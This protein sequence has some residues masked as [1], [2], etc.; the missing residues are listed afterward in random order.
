VR[1]QVVVPAIRGRDVAGAQWSGIRDRVDA[2]QPLDF[3][4]GPL[5]VHPSQYGPERWEG[6]L[7]GVCRKMLAGG[8][9][10]NCPTQAKERLEWAACPSWFRSR[11]LSCRIRLLVRR[12]CR[13]N[14]SYRTLSHFS[15]RTREMGH[16][17]C[18]KVIT[19]G[20]ST[21]LGMT[22][23]WWVLTL[24]AEIL[25][26]ESHAGACDSAASG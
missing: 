26:W 6:Q 11:R 4:N 5:G 8:L 7:A 12:R 15:H 16:P 9:G 17:V 1:E 13:G 20:P 19:Q 22:G 2:L 3:G 14:R 18:P 25:R 10:G 21:A 24:S 23:F